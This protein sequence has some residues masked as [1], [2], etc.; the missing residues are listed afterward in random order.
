[1]DG[2]FA[3]VLAF[4]SGPLCVRDAIASRLLNCQSKDAGMQHVELNLLWN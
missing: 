2:K 3:L 1:M 4:L